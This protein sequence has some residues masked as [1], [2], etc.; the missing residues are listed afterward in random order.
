MPHGTWEQNSRSLQ[1]F[2]S[3]GYHPLWP[4]FPEL[5]S[6]NVDLVT[7][8]RSRTPSSSAP[9]HRLHNAYGLYRASRFR[10]FPV[11]SPLLRESLLLSFPEVTKMFQFTSFASSGLWIHPEMI[12][13]NP[14]QVAPFGDPRISG[15]LHLSGAYRSLSRPSSPSRAKAHGGCLGTR[16]R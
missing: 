8:R 7:S 4:V 9:Q 13:H 10:L 15:C 5:F 2:R 14:H 3:R 16:R 11:R 6:Y 12:R 1:P